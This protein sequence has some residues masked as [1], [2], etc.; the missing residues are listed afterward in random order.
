MARD[1]DDDAVSEEPV[2]KRRKDREDDDDDRPRKRS[3][4]EADDDVEEDRSSKKKDSQK[5]SEVDKS[6]DKLAKP[7]PLRL[8]GAIV[9]ALAWGILGVYGSCLD[10]TRQ[11]NTEVFIMKTQREQEEK[12]R[13]FGIRFDDRGSGKGFRYTRIGA[14]FFYM[15]MSAVL[16][17]GAI[18]L[19]IRKRFGM[20]IAMGAPVAM[21]LVEFFAFVV[22]LL[23]TDFTL[24]SIDSYNVQYFVHIFFSLIVGGTIAFLLLN[25]DVSKSL[26]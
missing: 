12:L 11:I 3:S 6:A 5:A 10:T 8:T 21:L 9:A 7:M 25:K 18:V 17:G 15:L 14:S 26:T 1:E 23:I 16:L 19:M 20:Y 4:R 24:I 22:C 13:G 2:S